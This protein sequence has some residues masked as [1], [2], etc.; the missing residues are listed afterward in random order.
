MLTG[1]RHASPKKVRPDQVDGSGFLKLNKMW[2]G[3]GHH[4]ETGWGRETHRSGGR[5]RIRG[6]ETKGEREGQEEKKKD[7]IFII[8]RTCVKK[9]EGL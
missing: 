8:E 1:G 2:G 3:G 4:G 7:G 6:E 9:C 5:G